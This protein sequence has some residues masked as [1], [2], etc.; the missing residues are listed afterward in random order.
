[1]KRMQR[2]IAVLLV[3]LVLVLSMSGCGKSSKIKDTIREFEYACQNLDL[4]AILDTI[5]PYVADPIRLAL[6]L[7]SGVAG[8]DYEDMLEDVVDS[9]IGAAFGDRYDPKEF[10]DTIRITDIKVKTKGST[11]TV[12]CELNFEIAGEQFRR[13]ATIYMVEEDDAWY[14]SGIDPIT[15]V[16]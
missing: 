9:L 16:E 6:A 7:Y 13:D 11:A 5:D 8:E 14:I 10:L 15:D 3:A 12:T 2:I 1:M 4:D